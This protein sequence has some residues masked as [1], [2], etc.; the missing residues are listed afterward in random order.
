MPKASNPLQ[1]VVSFCL[2]H[3]DQAP[4]SRRI[5]LYRGLAEVCADEQECAMLQSLATELEAA[6]HRCREFAFK[7]KNGGRP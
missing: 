2:D 3:A 6:D 1:E 5:V 7:F 4:V